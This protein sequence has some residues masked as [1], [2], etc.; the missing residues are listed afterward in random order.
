MYR[1]RHKS[2]LYRLNLHGRKEDNLIDTDK[3]NGYSTSLTIIENF[4]SY[5]T[6]NTVQIFLQRFLKPPK[7]T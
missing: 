3:F 1:E 4:K 6:L 5:N 7:S 2:Y